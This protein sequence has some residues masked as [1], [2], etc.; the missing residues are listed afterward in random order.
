MSVQ[1]HIAFTVFRAPVIDPKKVA[2]LQ[3]QIK[4]VIEDDEGFSSMTV[5]QR[6]DDSFLFASIRVYDSL[7][8]TINGLKALDGNP[9]MFEA[10]IL[11]TDPPDMT[12]FCP[13]D[14]AI[15]SILDRP[16]GS[17]MSMSIRVAELGRKDELVQDLRDTMQ[18][19]KAING[20]VGHWIG[21][22]KDLEEE[23]ATMAFWNSRNAFD[24]SM[25]S[26]VPFK[27]R[28]YDRII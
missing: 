17:L 1:H 25:P 13:I 8:T 12:I 19:L 23:I 26:Y 4:E 3:Q 9:E 20:F 11:E 15:P 21:E 24:A 16:V 22:N 2:Y 28:L 10:R 14:D 6:V 18:N 27:I 7:E 5:W